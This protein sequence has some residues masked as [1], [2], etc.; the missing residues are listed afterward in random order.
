MN[1]PERGH[2]VIRGA[3]VLPMDPEIGDLASGDIEIRDGRIVA[4]GPDLETH[5]AEVIDGADRIAIPGFVDTHW[6][7]WTTL[8]RGMIGDGRETG[9]FKRKELL[10]PH[11]TPADTHT[12]VRLG[13]AEG[14]RAGITTVHDWAHNVLSRE[15]AEANLEALRSLGVRARWSYGAPSTTPGLSLSQMSTIMA[16][17]GTSVDEVMDIDLAAELRDAWV[18]GPGGDGSGSADADLLSVGVAVRGP[19]RSTPEVFKAEFARARELGL[20]ISMHCAG[21]AVEIAKIDQVA[22]LAEAGLLD[23]D[24]LLAHGNH[25]PSTAI[26]LIAHHGIPV[27]VSPMSE[28]RLAMGFPIIRELS[29]AGIRVSFSLDT[30]AIAGSA[31]PFEAMR[32]AVGT[33]NVRAAD[34]RALLPQRAL[35]MATIEGAR[36]L[37]LGA[38]TGSLTPGKRADIVLVATDRLGMTPVV[39]P[40]VAIVHSARPSD[41]DTVLVDGRVVVAGGR[42]SVADE[43]TIIADAER[44][45]VELCRRAGVQRG[46]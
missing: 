21:T 40:Y 32:V 2:L 14:L 20:P 34:A 24:L 44:A 30:T 36:T 46:G 27:S 33:E 15:D 7:V 29:D 38:V 3:R 17:V 16:S 10:G 37:G 13:I 28:L 6:H 23:D 19:S 35:E 42:L 8:M 22:V 11:F 4:V 41:V 12:G 18:A 9:Y 43:T 39:D 31:D 45:S 26:A 5:G 1:L 25:L